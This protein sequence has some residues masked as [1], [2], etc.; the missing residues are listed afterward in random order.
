MLGL[1][2]GTVRLVAHQAAWSTLFTE[3]RQRLA[4]ALA[5]LAPDIEHLGS[6]AVPG[7]VAKPILD[8]GVGVKRLEDAAS[9][10]REQ[11]ASLGYQA[12]GDRSGKGEL[13][14]AR[15]PDE[16]RTHY[17]HLLARDNP[18]WRAALVFRD[19]LR[20][21]AD[22]R[23]E[24]GALKLELADRHADDRAAYSAAKLTFIERVVAGG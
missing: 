15:G 17:L 22:L 10:A 3:E 24:Y 23:R 5:R 14:F 8:I 9:H 12:F 16:A 18:D 13:F 2:R 19:R 11:L 4:T 7:L 21:D 20:A 1:P 6:T